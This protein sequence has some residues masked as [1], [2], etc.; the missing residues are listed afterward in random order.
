MFMKFDEATMLMLLIKLS[1]TL[2]ITCSVFTLDIILPCI[3]YIYF[4]IK[5]YYHLFL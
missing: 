5:I 4:E 1:M 3:F 2:F